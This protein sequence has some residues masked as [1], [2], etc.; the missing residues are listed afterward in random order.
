MIRFLIFL[1]LAYI[2]YRT[3]KAI[4]RPKEELRGGQDKGVIDEM[5]QDPQCKTYVPK[6]EAVK[7]TIAGETH[8]FCSGACADKFQ[9]GA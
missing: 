9:K 2:A 5:V 1:I 6:R 7:R 3:V 8:F 4:F